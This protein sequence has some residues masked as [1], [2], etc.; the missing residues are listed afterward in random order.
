MEQ[1]LKELSNDELKELLIVMDILP[2]NL[3]EDL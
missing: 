3:E 1:N 2:D